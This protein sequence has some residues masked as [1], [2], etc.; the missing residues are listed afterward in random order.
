M[1]VQSPMPRTSSLNCLSCRNPYKTPDELPPPFSLKN[2]FCTEKCFFASPSQRAPNP[3]KLAQPRLS[4][5]KARSSPAK[6]YKFGCV[7]S[8]MAIHYP[9]ILMTGH[10]GANTPKFVPPRWGRPR[11]EPTQIS[12]PRMSARR[13]SGTSRCSPR[14]F[15]NCEFS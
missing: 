8:Y 10:I 2:L 9:G 14:H 15:S 3:P 7:C 4:R 5:V 6:G 13:M 1:S 12:K 11:F